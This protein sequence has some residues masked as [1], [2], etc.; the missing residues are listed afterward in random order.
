MIFRTRKVHTSVMV[1]V[2]TAG[3]V[4]GMVEMGIREK[5]RT[6]SLQEQA[7]AET[8]IGQISTAIQNA[9]LFEQIQSALAVLI[10]D[11][12]YWILGNLE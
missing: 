5:D 8:L 2:I 6:F 4:V 3:Q 12:G 10:L 11:I 9:N 1:P 7:L